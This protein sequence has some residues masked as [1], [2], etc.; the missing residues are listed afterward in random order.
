MMGLEEM[1]EWE[2]LMENLEEVNMNQ[3]EDKIT[4]GLTPNKIFSTSSLYRF[5]T[6]GGVSSSVAKKI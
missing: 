1:V 5:M 3:E 6:S 4:W 2:S